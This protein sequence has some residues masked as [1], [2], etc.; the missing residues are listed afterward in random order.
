LG[1]VG[2]L[3]ADV[4]RPVKGGVE[5]EIPEVHGG[6]LR[7]SLGEYTVDEQFYKFN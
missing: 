5:I 3:D 1:D 6:K 7:V 2:K 4:F